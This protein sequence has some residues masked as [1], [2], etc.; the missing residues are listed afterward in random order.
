MLLVHCVRLRRLAR[1]LNRWQ[2]QRHQ[3]ADDGDHHQELDERERLVASA[4]GRLRLSADLGGR[5]ILPSIP[6]PSRI[7][8]YHFLCLRSRALLLREHRWCPK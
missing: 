8:S 2:Q 3:H 4:D 1:R 7:D 6:V 5:L